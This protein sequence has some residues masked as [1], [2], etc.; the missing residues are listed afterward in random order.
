MHETQAFL[1]V[2][3]RRFL[4]K[5]SFDARLPAA[6][7][8]GNAFFLQRAIEIG[9][10]S[11]VLA[12]LKTHR[13]DVVSM[14]NCHGETLLHTAVL[15]EQLAIVQMLLLHGASPNAELPCHGISGSTFESVAPRSEN[16]RYSRLLSAGEATPVHYGTL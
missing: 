4:S 9:D 2:E 16:F 6:Q 5:H 13:E 1:G 11:L 14:R 8:S 3:D 10:L 7:G 12:Q 15:H